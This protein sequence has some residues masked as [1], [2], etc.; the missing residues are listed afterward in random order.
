MAAWVLLQGVSRFF[1]LTRK[2]IRQRGRQM[3][4]ASMS[5]CSARA[6]N[7]VLYPGRGK[8]CFDIKISRRAA[9]GANVGGVQLRPGIG[10]STLCGERAVLISKS[11]GGATSGAKILATNVGVFS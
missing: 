9:F 10:S 3:R 8:G 6:R 2:K 4:K 5:G 11:A 1:H 7:W